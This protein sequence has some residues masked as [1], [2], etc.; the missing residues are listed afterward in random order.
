MSEPNVEIVR[1]MNDMFRAGDR[2]ATLAF[3]SEDAELDTTRMPGG[4]VHHGPEGVRKFFT[5]W[6]GAWESFDVE[7]LEL[8][9]SGD[10]VVMISRISGIGRGSGAQV[11]MR[12]AD[13][14][15][16]EDGKIVRHVAYPDAAEALAELGLSSSEPG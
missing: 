15:L 4:G 8:I 14:F 10:T 1:R 5:R 2:D 16:L 6:L 13:V 9:E 12:A 3:Y 7:R 11:D